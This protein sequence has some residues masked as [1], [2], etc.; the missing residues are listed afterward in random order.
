MDLFE[1]RNRFRVTYSAIAE[2]CGCGVPTISRIASGSLSP[3]FELAL[4]IE[5]ATDGH[6]G[7][8]N[9][10]PSRPFE[11]TFSVGGVSA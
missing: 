1:Y 4:K 10:Y 5:L 7:R 9:W 11:I 3:S 8:E 6:V 2:Q